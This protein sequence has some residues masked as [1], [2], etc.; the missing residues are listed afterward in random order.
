MVFI[1][2]YDNGETKPKIST[3]L[4]SGFGADYEKE[5]YATKIVEVNDKQEC[6]V[7]L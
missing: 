5:F 7:S 6:E 2:P 1:V 3:N 4:I